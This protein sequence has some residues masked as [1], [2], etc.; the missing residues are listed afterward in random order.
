MDI[1][2]LSSLTRHIIIIIIIDSILTP[3]K[4]KNSYYREKSLKND[5]SSRFQTK[6]FMDIISPKKLLSQFLE[7]KFL[8]TFSVGHN[9][10]S[11]SY[12][13]LSWIVRTLKC[14]SPLI[15]D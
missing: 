14:L 6:D 5:L 10:T 8:R 3:K 13:F 1:I 11:L 4:K 15:Q 9:V 12:H 7:I 2:I